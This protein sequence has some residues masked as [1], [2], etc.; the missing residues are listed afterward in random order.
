[1]KNKFA[2]QSDGTTIIYYKS[3]EGIQRQ[4][5][6]DTADFEQ[7]SS[8][9]GTWFIS[10]TRKDGEYRPYCKIQGRTTYLYRFLLDIPD[11]YVVHH[12]NGDALDNRRINLKIIPQSHIPRNRRGAI[13]TSSNLCYF[14]VM[15]SNA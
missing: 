15:I 11:G 9:P 5:L 14:C 3:R 7:V 4:T 13:K 8:I 6:I 12:I 1:M 10:R 2:H